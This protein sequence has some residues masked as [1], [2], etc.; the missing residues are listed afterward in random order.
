MFYPQPTLGLHRTQTGDTMTPI[1][2]YI[3][4]LPYLLASDDALYILVLTFLTVAIYS[5]IAIHEHRQSIL[6]P[7][8]RLPLWS[9]PKWIDR[10]PKVNLMLLFIESLA[11]ICTVSSACP[12]LLSHTS[13]LRSIP[14]IHPRP[15]EAR[16]P[17]ERTYPEQRYP[18]QPYLVT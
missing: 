11:N 6:T 15:H 7:P 9:S 2:D 8:T 3:Y 1:F 13:T 4:T 10:L 5:Q 16:A 18:P 14:S 17:S 12:L